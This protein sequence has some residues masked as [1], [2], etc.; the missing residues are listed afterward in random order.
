MTS[1]FFNRSR[2]CRAAVTLLATFCLGIGVAAADSDDW[3]EGSV[4]PPPIPNLQKLVPFEFKVNAAL[5]YGIDPQSI[6]VGKDRVVRYVIVAQSAA[7]ATNVIYE[8]IRCDTAEF[9]VY[10]R[11]YPDE[12]W[13]SPDQIE[14]KSLYDRQ[15][16]PH[17]LALA[18]AGACIGKAPTSSAAQLVNDLR[19]P[20]I[21][22][23]SP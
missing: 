6:T 2:S 18:R 17:T 21:S 7:G 1:D 20:D 16:P 12:G 22:R 5:H 15:M 9:K 14:W 4:P 3:Q 8:G 19:N 11:Y 23:A 10:A 13:H